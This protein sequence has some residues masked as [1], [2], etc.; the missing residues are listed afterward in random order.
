MI[1]LYKYLFYSY[2]Y[3]TMK[4]D[5]VWQVGDTYFVGGGLVMGW[6]VTATFLMI[7]E[8]I[9]FIF[10]A[11]A[12]DF[13]HPYIGYV[14]ACVGIGICIYLGH[15]RRNDRIYKEM[16]DMDKSKKRVFKILN[17]IFLIVVNVGLMVVAEYARYL[18]GF[19]S[20]LFD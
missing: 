4:Y 16:A 12:L 8:I 3:V 9:G 19:S 10:P 6:M 13:W 18:D 1:T 20:S 17:I 5:D 15:G 7:T 2:S 11:L 14:A